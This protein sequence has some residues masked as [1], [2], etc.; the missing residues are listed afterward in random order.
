M[1]VLVANKFWYRRGGLER[2]MFDEIAWLEKAGH[3]VAHFSTVH[4]ANEYSPWREYFAPYLELGSEGG[5]SSG[6]KLTAALRMFSNPDARRRFTQLLADFQPDIIH[7]HGV[8]RQISPSILEAA[9]KAG[10]PIVQTLHDYHHICPADVLLWRG[11]AVCEPRRCGRLCHGAAVR[12]RCV[13]GSLAA[14]ALSAAETSFQRIRGIYERT[15][16]RFISPSTFLADAMSSG[17]WSIPCDVVP[18]AVPVGSMWR[19]GKYALFAGRLSHEKG[20]STLLEAAQ[21]A[22]VPVK[23]AGEG[24]LTG[25][26]RSR[27]KSAEF[28]GRVGGDTVQALIE[29]SLACVVPS[30]WYENAPMSVLEPMAA[31]APVVASAIGGIPELVED[32][33]SGLLVHAGDV[34]DL[35]RALGLLRDDKGLGARLGSAARARVAQHFSP[36]AHLAGVLR[37][38][39]MAM[40]S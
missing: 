22:G 10:I 27:F 13:R 19:G 9:H 26:L 16:T 34:E 37:T 38:Y 11:Q 33:V 40:H 18:N 14:S 36:E 20:V 4:P 35:S 7:V 39:E 15:V 6:E 1:R 31:G 28:L 8:H 25:E 12:G 5:L 23:V 24:P 29:E 32:E 17:G 21:R 2:V 30:T 3:D